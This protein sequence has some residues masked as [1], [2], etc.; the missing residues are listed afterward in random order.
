VTQH[1]L[2]VPEAY[3]QY[4]NVMRCATDFS[5][6]PGLLHRI[7]V[8]EEVLKYDQMLLLAS[9]CHA[10]AKLSTQAQRDCNRKKWSQI[11]GGS[12][13]LESPSER[14]SQLG[15]IYAYMR[16][17]IVN[18]K[19]ALETMGP[20]GIH[21]SLSF[22]GTVCA[23]RSYQWSDIEYWRS[24]A[25]SSLPQERDVVWIPGGDR[26]I[27]D[28]SPPVL[29]RLVIEGALIF[30]DSKD[31]ELQANQIAVVAGGL[32]Q[33]GTEAAPFTHRATITLHGTRGDTPISRWGSKVLAVNGV[34]ELHGQPRIPAW[35]RLA[36][37]TLPGG[38][39]PQQITLDTTTWSAVDPSYAGSEKPNWQTGDYVVVGSTSHD[40][41]QTEV[42]RLA[43][44][45]SQLNLGDTLYHSHV[46]AAYTFGFD[47]S[48]EFEGRAA[49]ACL[50]R[51]VVVRGVESVDG[52]GCSI[53]LQGTARLADVEIRNC[54]KRGVGAPAVLLDGRGPATL[55]GYVRGTVV[56]DSYNTGIAT[57]GY[58]SAY[59]FP[60]TLAGNVVYRAK[61]SAFSLQSPIADVTGN[62]AL[63]TSSRGPAVGGIGFDVR[64]IG[65]LHGNVAVGADLYGFRVS[66]EL[67][68]STFAP[69]YPNRAHACGEACVRIVSSSAFSA[70]CGRL[71]GFVAMKGRK[72]AFSSRVVGELRVTGVVS[73]DAA[74][75]FALDVE[76]GADLADTIVT[77]HDV[78]VIARVGTDGGDAP[79]IPSG[80]PAVP[81][82]VVGI[83]PAR[84]FAPGYGHAVPRGYLEI[85]QSRFVN[86]RG[87]QDSCGPSWSFMTADNAAESTTAFVTFAG[88]MSYD[89]A[90]SNDLTWNLPSAPTTGGAEGLNHVV[91]EDKDGTLAG[92]PNTWLM[93][94]NVGMAGDWSQCPLRNDYNALRCGGSQSF[95]RLSVEPFRAG[96]AA[97]TGWQKL[98]VETVDAAETN[99]CNANSASAAPS[100]RRPKC[101]VVSA[102]DDL[103][104]F[105]A[106][107]DIAARH[108]IRFSPGAGLVASL[109]LAL[110]TSVPRS[111]GAI[112]MVL[113]V[114]FP[115]VRICASDPMYSSTM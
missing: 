49:V 15:E 13:Y 20:S 79:C 31:L 24:T 57:R 14:I 55:S 45:G 99:P 108:R 12:Q 33:V 111:G 86:F 107:L 36:Q 35:G 60:V 98:T 68:S 92:V 110:L 94:R 95:A 76:A 115:P 44:S 82:S 54:G 51:N 8:I 58:K 9:A 89:G 64:A 63:S 113:D 23:P 87:L 61:G 37:T 97:S 101:D 40:A 67:C 29:G 65:T 56:R 7:N 112:A 16:E 102:A 46:G 34:V 27:L 3:S 74:V 28:V 30:E 52:W 70:R 78:T 17:F 73:I 47:G 81:T 11:S 41:R 42:R 10:S 103:G 59:V 2:R 80:D 83:V 5:F 105:W 25:L 32:L 38:S 96:G 69:A 100:G 18:R 48:T 106:A 72:T 26:I 93:T 6:G 53:L 109:R 21:P 39:P 71:T 91:L 4:L 62:L 43:A 85:S 77:I 1:L 75:H 19:E 104:R 66:P 90:T 84:F 88:M 22:S 50:S 114:V